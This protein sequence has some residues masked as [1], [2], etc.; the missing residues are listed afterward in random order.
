M[1]RIRALIAQV[2]QLY[3]QLSK[4]EQ[5]LVS[6]AGV[7]FVVFISSILYAS[8][9][10]SMHRH[11]LSIDDKL[12]AL[13]KVQTYAQSYAANERARKEL[14]SKLTSTTSKFMTQMQEIADKNQLSIAGM[15]E[16]GENTTDSVKET[17]FDVQIREAPIEKLT[18]ALN[19]IEHDPHIVKIRK[20][21]IRALGPES[22]SVN[23]NFTVSAYSL[24]TKP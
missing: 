3:G 21:N 12:D 16:H 19:D 4:R 22:K 6:L 18:A 9:T 2:G 7:A 13:A 20:L 24:A 11:L 10:S 1:E 14:E 8:A 23:A 17:M 5:M 15:S